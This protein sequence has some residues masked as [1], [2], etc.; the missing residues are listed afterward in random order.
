[1]QNKTPQIFHQFIANLFGGATFTLLAMIITISKICWDCAPWSIS[2]FFIISILGI[3]VTKIITKKNHCR[4]HLI[5]PGIFI[6]L[7]MLFLFFIGKEDWVFVDGFGLVSV[8]YSII[9]A[10]LFTAPIP[11]QTWLGI[12]K[13]LLAFFGTIIFAL[14]FFTPWMWMMDNGE[15]IIERYYL[16]GL[17]DEPNALP[18]TGE[19]G[20][21]VAWAPFG[22]KVYGCGE[23][24]QQKNH[25]YLSFWGQ[26]F[27]RNGK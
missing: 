5:A 23:K 20:I 15:D 22:V 11:W 3:V 26:W 24:S 25:Y 6:A 4:S 7:E 2:I 27:Y 18:A 21:W 12:K 17:Y 16:A 13:L 1:M 14:L 8:L 19:C 9:P 10:L